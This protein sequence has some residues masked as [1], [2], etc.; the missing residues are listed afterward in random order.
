MKLFNMAPVAPLASLLIGS[1]A[2]ALVPQTIVQAELTTNN[3][4]VAQ[5]LL[6]TPLPP[7]P[8]L[9]QTD[10]PQ[11]LAR[12]RRPSRTRTN[13]RWRSNCQRQRCNCEA[14]PCDYQS[15]VVY[16]PRYSDRLLEQVQ[17]IYSEARKMHYG[18]KDV[19]QVG[20]YGEQWVA[21]DTRA[22][23]RQEGFS[24]EIG[25][26][27][28]RRTS[29]FSVIVNNPSLLDM[30]QREVFNATLGIDTRTQQKVIVAGQY[31]SAARAQELVSELQKRGILAEIVGDV[32]VL[33]TTEFSNDNSTI[34]VLG[35]NYQ[36]NLLFA[37]N[38]VTRSNSFADNY[39]GIMIPGSE[40]ELT[41]IEAHVR[42]MAPGLGMERGV[43]QIENAKEPF[44][45]VGPFADR[46]TAER[47]GRYLQDF[48]MTNAQVF[49][50][51]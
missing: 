18:R 16:I 51:S 29:Q 6:E 13:R 10:S 19:I 31:R 35:D 44:V 4:S 14:T 3:L 39:Y 43:Y 5:R 28:T 11:L 32:S 33:D 38:V 50:G 37:N 40:A 49:H 34:E 2:L 41:T 21:E 15:Y 9:Q 45:M 7:P 17:N 27:L 42:R 24:T 25:T 12:R 23:L 1:M 36:S 48:G 47:W 22:R 30:V 26:I 8:R 46:E 20:S